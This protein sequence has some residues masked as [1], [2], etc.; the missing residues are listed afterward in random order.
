MLTVERWKHKN[1]IKEWKI[2]DVIGAKET[3]GTEWHRAKCVLK[4]D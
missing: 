2:T 1:K 4:A 3:I